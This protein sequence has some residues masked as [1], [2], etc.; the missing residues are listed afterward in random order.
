MAFKLITLNV[1]GICCARKQKHLFDFIQENDIKVVCLQEH[2]L[3]SS[4]D[5]SSIFYEQFHVILNDSIKLKG[6]TC[7]L[8][9]KI[10]INSKII[11]IEKSA[12][13]RVISVKFTINDTLIHILNLYAPSG[14]NQHKERESLFKD[15]ILYY[16]RNN[17]SNTILCGDFNCIINKKDHSLN[18]TCPI[19]KTLPLTLGSLN[20]KD[21]WTSLNRKIEFTYFRENYG[22]CI[23]RI[24]A[25]DFKENFTKIWVRPVSFSDHSCI[26][27]L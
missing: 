20:L 26:F 1:N 12:D 24:Y 22:S 7:V 8:I 21:I 14:T 23:D 5:L 13:S 25:A 9:D 27:F 11:S 3:K 17:L 15:H 18:G 10:S 16:L 4:N 6:G 19:S 2:N